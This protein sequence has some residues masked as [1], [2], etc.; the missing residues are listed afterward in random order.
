ML[1]LSSDALM[2]LLYWLLFSQLLDPAYKNY[3]KKMIDNPVVANA[4]VEVLYKS[5]S[6]SHDQFKGPLNIIEFLG[7][8]MNPP[9]YSQPTQLMVD[10]GKSILGDKEWIYTL[11]NTNGITRSFKDTGKAYIKSK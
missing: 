9:I 6:R 11:T 5:A 4:L 8:N 2:T 3:K 10:M 1:K 7:T